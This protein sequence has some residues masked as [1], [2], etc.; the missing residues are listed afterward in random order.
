MQFIDNLIINFIIKDIQAFE[1]QEHGKVSF[2]LAVKYY[3][4]AF[5]LL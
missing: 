1:I 5:A 3:L 4:L 2:L